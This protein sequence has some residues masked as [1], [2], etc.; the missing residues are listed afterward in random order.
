M[1]QRRHVGRAERRRPRRRAGRRTPGRRPPRPARC[2]TMWAPRAARRTA[3]SPHGVT[4]RNDGPQLVV[5]DD[6]A[7][8]GRRRR[9]RTVT[10]RALG[11]AGHGRHPGV[12]GVEH[13]RSRRRAAPRP[14]RPWPRRRRRASRT[15]RCGPRPPRVTTPTVGPG[16]GAQLGDVPGA[17]G[18][19]LDDEG[20]GAVGGVEQRERHAQLVVER[21]GAGRRAPAGGQGRGQQVLDAG[22]AHRAGDAHHPVVDPRVSGPR[23]WRPRRAPGPRMC[24]RPRPRC[25]RF[26][27]RAAG[28]A[29]R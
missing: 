13:R 25:R 12:A 4:S 3:A 5:E 7:R 26:A 23:A 14:A 9:R 19:H 17:A 28:R 2:S 27:G 8:P 6:L 10:T 1:R 15:S 16:D 11:A 18:A 20:L 22:L 29:V 24:R 21:P